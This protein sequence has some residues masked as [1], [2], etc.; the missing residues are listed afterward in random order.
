MTTAPATALTTRESADE[1][2]AANKGPMLAVLG[3]PDKDTPGAYAMVKR[4]ARGEIVAMRAPIALSAALGHYHKIRG[5]QGLPITIDGYQYLNRVMGI[6]R[7]VPDRMFGDDGREHPNPYP[8]ER[9]GDLLRWVYRMGGYGRNDAGN[10]VLQIATVHYEV[11]AYFANELYEAW[12]EMKF[13]KIGK[14][15]DTGKDKWKPDGRHPGKSW[16][17][18]YETASLPDEVRDAPQTKCVN[19]PGGITLACDLNQPEAQELLIGRLSKIIKFSQRIAE[20]IAWERVLRSFVGARR[21]HLS[22]KDEK[23]GVAPVVNLTAWVTP[24]ASNVHD[25]E[26][27][28]EAVKAGRT[29][30]SIPGTQ[31]KHE[32]VSVD[33][34]DDEDREFV[35]AAVADEPETTSAPQAPVSPPVKAKTP[36]PPTPTAAAEPVAHQAPSPSKAVLSKR[37]R[38]ATLLGEVGPE[39]APEILGSNGLRGLFELHVLTEKG[40]DALITELETEVGRQ[41]TDRATNATRK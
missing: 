2:P 33:G 35:S 9:G 11:Q 34:S 22:E 19:L 40:L 27:L 7:I 16:G 20:S 26:G 5:V 1:Q 21:V 29:D 23:A 6:S 39:T 38:A 18:P 4:T 32:A 30:V 17:V 24:D 12:A 28:A 13:K 8:V 36:A 3:P 37:K 31:V 41:Q 25:I 15:K 10:T 14:D